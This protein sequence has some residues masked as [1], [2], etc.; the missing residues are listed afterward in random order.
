MFEEEPLE[1]LVSMPQEFG[2]TLPYKITESE[3]QNGDT[4]KLDNV[5]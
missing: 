5:C 2:G 1:I 3:D 4:G